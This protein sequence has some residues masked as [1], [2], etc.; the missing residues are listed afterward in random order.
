MIK[1]KKKYGQNF[2]VD[3]GVINKIIQAINPNNSEKILEIGPGLG[4][5][6]TQILNKIDHIN[7]V[8]IDPDM[9]KAL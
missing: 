9:I 6:T 1:A 7:V 4:A 2:L 3:K 8:E 5:L